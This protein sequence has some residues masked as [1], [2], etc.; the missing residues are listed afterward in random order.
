MDLWTHA[1]ARTSAAFSGVCV[2]T[3]GASVHKAS[4]RLS[5]QQ[6]RERTR[7]G[8]VWP[9]GGVVRVRD[10]ARAREVRFEALAGFETVVRGFVRFGVGADVAGF[11]AAEGSGSVVEDARAI[12]VRG[13][14]LAH[15]PT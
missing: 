3:D 10:D 12:L 8:R 5:V 7:R 6:R 1:H 15:P 14:D 4:K 13:A 9:H 2:D 11:A